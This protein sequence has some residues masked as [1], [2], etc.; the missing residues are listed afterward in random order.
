MMHDDYHSIVVLSNF[1][2]IFEIYEYNRI[3]YFSLNIFQIFW[4]SM[5]Q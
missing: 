4:I 1:A 3:C 2:K 5:V